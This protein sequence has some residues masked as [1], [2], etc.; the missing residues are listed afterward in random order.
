VSTDDF[1]LVLWKDSR[2]Q[3]KNKK[4]EGKLSFSTSKRKCVCMLL[5]VRRRA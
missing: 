5:C 3:N 1:I 2:F 4:V